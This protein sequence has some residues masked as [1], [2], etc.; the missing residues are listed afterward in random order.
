MSK[1]IDPAFVEL[2]QAV[3]AFEDLLPVA[4]DRRVVTALAQFVR[5]S[6]PEECGIA[7]E[8]LIKACAA[9]KF[10]L[11]KDEHKA[12]F[13]RLRKCAVAAVAKK[14]GQRSDNQLAALPTHQNLVEANTKACAGFK[15]V[16]RLKAILG[17]SN[18]MILVGEAVIIFIKI[19]LPEAL[20][21]TTVPTR[22]RA[23]VLAASEYF[24]SDYFSTCEQE[25][26]EA[27][28]NDAA[29]CST[30]TIKF[31]E[32]G[33]KDCKLIEVTRRL[34]WHIVARVM[35]YYYAIEENRINERAN[36]DAIVRYFTPYD[37]DEKIGYPDHLYRPTEESPGDTVEVEEPA[38]GEA[39]KSAA[40]ATDQCNGCGGFGHFK[41][42]CASVRN[43]HLPVSRPKKKA[44]REMYNFH[45]GKKKRQVRRK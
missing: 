16:N 15:L 2:Q 11:H 14:G 33:D 24:H 21:R 10:D 40:K 18:S 17:S 42:E 5:V 7:A 19:V 36:V 31:D 37:F 45:A 4:A 30:D 23:S 32:Y 13:K 28:A 22:H 38:S 27:I 9:M 39:A 44:A 43:G 26:A 29:P 3:D 12:A 34:M 8:M 20:N 1:E 6:N 41:E 35:M 25:V